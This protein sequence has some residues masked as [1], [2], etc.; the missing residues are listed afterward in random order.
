MSIYYKNKKYQLSKA[1][2]NIILG[3]ISYFWRT[4]EF[5]WKRRK[6]RWICFFSFT[7]AQILN[8]HLLNL[9]RKNFRLVFVWVCNCWDWDISLTHFTQVVSKYWRKMK[10]IQ[11]RPEALFFIT[12]QKFLVKKRPS[13]LSVRNKRHCVFFLCVFQWRQP[14]RLTQQHNRY[15]PK[16]LH[17]LKHT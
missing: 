12:E 13:S 17:Y 15:R 2:I 8:N 3:N 10:S 1:A 14:S 7:L 6:I 16:Y 5:L 4:I 11:C 9:L